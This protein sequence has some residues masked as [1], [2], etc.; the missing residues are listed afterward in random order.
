MA[1]AL[2]GEAVEPHHGGPASVA[3]AVAAVSTVLAGRLDQGDASAGEDPKDGDEARRG[4]ATSPGALTVTLRV[5]Q[6]NAGLPDIPRL[7][8]QQGRSAPLAVGEG[9]G[10]KGED[11]RHGDDAQR[12]EG[13]DA[14]EAAHGKQEYAMITW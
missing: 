1:G 11:D 9:E 12:N 10:Q 14:L 4:E 5:H 6:P 3:I 7:G 2:A 8:S 13:H